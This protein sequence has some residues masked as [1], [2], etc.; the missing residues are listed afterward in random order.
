MPEIDGGQLV[1]KAL[2]K[3]GVTHLF[4]LSGGHLLPIYNACLDAGIKLID[5]RHEQAAG[6]MA[7]G[8]S[9]VTRTMGVCAVT[10]GP[11]LTD[12]ITAVANAYQSNTPMIVLG[13]RSAFK[14]NDIGT[15][16]DID[17]MALMKS[18]TKWS[19]I[20]HQTHRIPEYVSMAF[21]HAWGGRPGPI[22]LELPMD[23][24]YAKINE[25]KVI[26]PTNY[27][28]TS[29]PTGDPE[30]IEKA[31]KIIAQSERPL[32]LAGSGCLWSGAEKSLKA[33]AE[34]A[35]IPVITRCSGRGVLPDSHPLAISGSVR[36]MIPALMQAD[37]V[38]AL[39]TR[40]NFMLM[41]GRLFQSQ[42]KI[43]QVDIESTEIGFNRAIDVGIFG[44][45][46]QVLD[47]LIAKIPSNP[48]R[49]WAADAKKMVNDFMESMRATYNLNS[50]P[51][52]PRHV[53]EVVRDIVGGEGVYICDGGDSML[54]GSEVFPAERPASAIATGPL[55]CLGVGLPF[56][57]AA[58][59]AE[60]KRTVVLFSGDG[61]FG[62]NGME[63][64]TAVRHC[65]PILCIICNDQAW[66]MI[67]CGQEMYFGADRTCACDLGPVRYDLMVQG[68]G[69]HGEFVERLE[70]IRPAIERALKSGKPACVNVIC[71][72][73]LHH[74]VTVLAS[75][76]GLF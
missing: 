66:G 72:P 16:Q 43:I 21:R 70:D 30:T 33:F 44:D 46:K 58:K 45:V 41:Y 35:G 31:L 47:S 18:I 56:A 22:Y 76:S 38:I 6:H 15:L 42:V 1:V 25:D 62:L 29:R 69:G 39:G 55:G 74:P 75:Q 9:L 65:I 14:E 20:C 71:D 23:I 59:I 4:T 60:P 48:K 57:L 13:G 28:I 67:K 17:Q 54:W 68:L 27:R 51:M 3:E 19:R 7:E 5:T 37:T 50:V 36:D 73:N 26:Y 64:D 10:A 61:T 53:A 8:W 32:I 63:F 49:Q 40:F 34:K 52:H 2:Q 24:L 11:G 12:V